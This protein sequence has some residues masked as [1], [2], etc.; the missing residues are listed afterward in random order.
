MDD[1]RG[2]GIL[3][4]SF[5]PVHNGH[6]AIVESFLG[7][8]YLSELWILLTPDPPHKPDQQLTD[9]PIRLEMLN[10]AF[11]GIDKVAIK[12]FE[13]QLPKP[14][15]TLQTLQFIKEKYPSNKLYLCIG[16]DS[17]THF[18]EWYKWESIL[19]YCE[20]LVARRPSSQEKKLDSEL[21]TKTT[22]VP[23][24]PIEISSTEIREKV[25]AGEAISE[26]VPTNVETLI[27]KYNL[28]QN[29]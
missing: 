3:G 20:L 4:G 9:Y 1:S 23:H 6:L 19:N 14:S 22:F 10:A 21:G 13:K 8:G 25:A 11:Q 18:K 29:N 16:G 12:E 26:L 5:D 15:Y 2:I 7:S 24:V 28:Y 17:L 27:K